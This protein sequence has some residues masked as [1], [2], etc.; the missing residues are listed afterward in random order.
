MPSSF[1]CGHEAHRKVGQYPFSL[2]GKEKNQQT[3]R[4]HPCSFCARRLDPFFSCFLC[5]CRPVVP[6]PWESKA[7]LGNLS[8]PEVSVGKHG[9]IFTASILS[10]CMGDGLL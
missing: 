6:A 1:L 2:S 4:E 9:A 7:S 3:N 5:W 8:K 10:G